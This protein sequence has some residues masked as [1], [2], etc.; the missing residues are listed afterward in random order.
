[1]NEFPELNFCLA[2][3]GG[4]QEWER[5]LTGNLSQDAKDS[6][7]LSVI[8]DMLRS[9]EYPNLYTDVS[10]TLF[11]ESPSYR[12][13]SYFDYLKVMMVDNNIRTHVLFGSDYYMV[14]QEKI[15]EKEVSIALRSRLGE[16]MYFQ[17]ANENPKNYLYES[18]QPFGE[19]DDEK[20][21]SRAWH[22]AL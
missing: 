14:E 10:Y 17:I 7:W 16:E 3:F 20:R 4:T 12:P 22:S 15:S 9:G 2:H 11:S 19:S 8:L 13:F 6:S 18:S 1:L 5:R 21:I